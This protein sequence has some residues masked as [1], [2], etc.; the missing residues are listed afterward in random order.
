MTRKVTFRFEGANP[1]GHPPWWPARAPVYLA[2]TLCAYS[3]SAE[4]MPKW[5]GIAFTSTCFVKRVNVKKKRK[6]NCTFSPEKT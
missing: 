3:L 2:Q 1:S 4:K 6:G 5:P